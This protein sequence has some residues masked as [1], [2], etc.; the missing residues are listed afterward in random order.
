MGCASRALLRQL[1]TRLC[2]TV[3]RCP[4]DMAAHHGMEAAHAAFDDCE[5]VILRSLFAVEKTMISDK[6]C[7]ELYGYDVRTA[8]THS[9]PQRQTS[10]IHGSG[11]T[12]G[13]WSGSA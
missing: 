9:P 7:F 1:C 8:R 5:M 2:P 12:L 10:A 4:L 11:G 6:H 13:G 3:L